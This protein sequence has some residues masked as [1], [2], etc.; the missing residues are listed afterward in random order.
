MRVYV[1][2]TADTKGEEL[3]FLRD[4]IRAEAARLGLREERDLVAVA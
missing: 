2:G 3:R 1:V 4:A